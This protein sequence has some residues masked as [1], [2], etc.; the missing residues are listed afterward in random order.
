MCILHFT[1]VGVDPQELSQKTEVR[2]WQDGSAAKGVCYQRG[3]PEFHPW[4][5]I[6]GRR[7][8]T[9]TNCHL[10]STGESPGIHVLTKQIHK[11]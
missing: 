2:N 7:D 10:T 9:L 1:N 5:H 8:S 4:D 6:S 11:M 3:Q